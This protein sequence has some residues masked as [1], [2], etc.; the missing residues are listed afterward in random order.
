MAASGSNDGGEGGC[1]RA[2]ELGVEEAWEAGEGGWRH[3]SSAAV[4]Q[5]KGRASLR[6]RA[7]GRR[8]RQRGKRPHSITQD[9]RRPDRAPHRPKMGLGRQQRGRNDAGIVGGCWVA[10]LE[11]GEGADAPCPVASRPGGHVVDGEPAMSRFVESRVAE[12]ECTLAWVVD[13]RGGGRRW[14]AQCH[15]GRS[16]RRRWDLRPRARPCGDA[17]SFSQVVAR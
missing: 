8:P 15:R 11:Y 4:T 6:G 12:D 9:R 16:P 14:R 10:E 2:C 7:R 13:G 17:L 3:A 5:E 1:H